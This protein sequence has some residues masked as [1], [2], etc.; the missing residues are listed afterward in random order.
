MGK[1]QQPPQAGSVVAQK[2]A[3]GEEFG[4]WSIIYTTDTGRWWA[5]R[6]VRRARPDGRLVG[7]VV[8]V[9]EADTAEGLRQE[10]REVTAADATDVGEV[11]R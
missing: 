7:R 6:T 9:V 8:T 2:V 1:V 11:V 10:L 3:L 4:S 5:T